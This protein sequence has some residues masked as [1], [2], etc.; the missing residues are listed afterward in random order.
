MQKPATEMMIQNK[1]RA[2]LI[3]E[4]SVLTKEN[5]ALSKI[6]EIYLRTKRALEKERARLRTLYK[7]SSE[8]LLPFGEQIEMALKSGVAMLN[9]KI[10]TV[11]RIEGNTYTI[12]YFNTDDA[13]LKRGQQFKLGDTYCALTMQNK[14]VIAIEHMQASPH[15]GHPCYAAFELEAYIGVPLIVNGEI[16]GTLSFSN[17]EPLDRPFSASDRDFVRLM[18]RWV[19]RVLEHEQVEVELT[20]YRQDLEF[21]VEKRTLDLNETNKTLRAEIRERLEA[22]ESLRKS[23]LLMSSILN[24]SLD[25]IVT[26]NSDGEIIEFNPSAEK[27]FGFSRDEIIGKD[28]ITTI[29]PPTYQEAHNKGWERYSRTGQGSVFGKRIEI[30]AMHADGV[31]FPVELTITKLDLSGKEVFTA[32][33]RDISS[34]VRAEKEAKNLEAQLRQAQKMEAIGTMAGG[35]AHDFNNILSAVIGY[36]EMALEDA[37]TGSHL[38]SRLRQVFDAGQRARD[39]V[40]RILAIS[41]QTDQ[42]LRPV[43]MGPIVEEVQKFIRA[44]LPTTIEIESGLTSNATIMGDPTQLHQVVMNLCTN[45]GHAMSD[46]GKL[47]LRLENIELT[48]ETTAKYPNLYPGPHIKLT[49]TDTGVGIPADTLDKIFDPFFTT[50]D[51][52]E[53]TGL[54]LAVVHGIIDSHKG[55]IHVKSQTG[56]GSTFTI[57]L[58]RVKSLEAAEIKD[59]SEIPGGSEHILFI[60][61]EKPLIDLGQEMLESLGYRVTAMQ[62][63]L[64][65]LKA[66]RS[67]ALL[68]DLVITDMTMPQMTGDKLALELMKIRPDIPVILCSGFHSKMNK[69]KAMA[70]GLRAFVSKPMLKRQIA[71]VVRKVLDST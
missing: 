27:T 54:G 42:D 7:I 13:T 69:D 62:S 24:S 23:E 1:T 10:G 55:A 31:E 59:D 20:K 26:V 2:Q 4:I 58:P 16:F 67:D 50:K 22:E 56:R 51:K 34:R 46:G 21:L 30:M 61:D 9:M 65:A 64:E 15:A 38:E 17:P 66:F 29:V 40:E 25:C 14:D 71:M 33:I 6:N 39:L 44:S 41:R 68:F 3:E 49:V 47:K 35:I 60:D 19:A 52:G 36:T 57:L 53:G 28:L 32:F 43:Q 5:K 45:A 63:G 8:Q 37:A 18:G 48:P 11:S 12:V 70:M